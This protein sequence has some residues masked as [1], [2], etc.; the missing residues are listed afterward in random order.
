M[1]RAHLLLQCILCKVCTALRIPGL[2]RRAGALQEETALTDHSGRDWPVI[3]RR[4][5]TIYICLMFKFSE[6]ERGPLWP[7]FDQTFL[8]FNRGPVTVQR[9]ARWD[10]ERRASQPDTVSITGPSCNWRRCVTL[11]LQTWCAIKDQERT[12]TPMLP[13]VHT[14][15]H[16]HTHTHARSIWRS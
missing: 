14:D 10:R 5:R 8:N 16:A 12:P 9:Y 3:V 13:L 1:G 6:R 4:K 2:K 7:I 11:N 15:L